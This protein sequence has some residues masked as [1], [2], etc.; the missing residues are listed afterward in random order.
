VDHEV[1]AV[2]AVGGATVILGP[3]AS[4]GAEL[5]IALSAETAVPA[6]DI[7]VDHSPVADLRPGYA[8]T[9]DHDLATRLMPGPVLRVDLGR[10]RSIPMQVTPTHSGCTRLDQDLVRSGFNIREIGDFGFTI[11]QEADASHG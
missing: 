1:L 4:V 3:R 9:E 5:L 7:V 2:T 6:T 8:G 11:A 10:R